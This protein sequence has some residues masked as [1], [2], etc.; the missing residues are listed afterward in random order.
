MRVRAFGPVGAAVSSVDAVLAGV[1]SGGAVFSTAA[2]G[3]FVGLGGCGRQGIDR[4]ERQPRY[5]HLR[6]AAMQLT[7]R[8]GKRT[9]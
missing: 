2:L 9:V 3:V 6:K 8:H 1:G 7:A 4:H 5:G